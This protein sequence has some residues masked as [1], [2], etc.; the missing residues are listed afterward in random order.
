MLS[1][2]V[3]RMP[4]HRNSR[5]QRQS[6]H[7]CE[8]RSSGF[9]VHSSIFRLLLHELLTLALD[10]AEAGPAAQLPLNISVRTWPLHPREVSIFTNAVAPQSAFAG[11]IATSPSGQSALTEDPHWL[12]SDKLP[13]QTP[14]ETGVPFDA[15]C[16]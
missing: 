10:D 14:V 2:K 16:H 5:R 4:G 9:H 15:P 12:G 1:Y 6:N 8:T 11:L 3:L 13:V 7:D